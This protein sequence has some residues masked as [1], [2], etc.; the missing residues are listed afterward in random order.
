MTHRLAAVVS[1]GQTGADRGGLDAAIQLDIGWG[2]WAPLGWR[3]EDGVIPEIYRSH[4]RE[5]VSSD[6]GLRTRLNV[7]DSD[8]TL[9]VSF[10]SELTGGS[11]YTRKQCVAQRKPSRHLVLPARGE[12]RIPDGVRSAVLEWITTARISVLNIAGPRESKEPG[13]QLAV[14]DALV[15]IFEDELVRDLAGEGA[16][17]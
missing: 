9:L 15:W 6:Y 16:N 13:L 8:G 7:Q 3:A 5:S 14:R 11:G 12:T 17:Q 10:A 1:G 2:G 4:M